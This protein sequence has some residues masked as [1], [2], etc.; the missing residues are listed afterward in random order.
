MGVYT[1]T[2]THTQTLERI[3]LGIKNLKIW[4]ANVSF[5][6][7][8]AEQHSHHV[9]SDQVLQRGMRT[10]AKFIDK[11]HGIDMIKKI[12]VGQRRSEEAKQFEESLWIQYNILVRK[13]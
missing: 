8:V 1:C 12:H 13:H 2:H 3:A 4:K 5:P 10:F 9:G 6:S 11:D 7:A